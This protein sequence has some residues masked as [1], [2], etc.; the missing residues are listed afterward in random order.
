MV[1]L[2]SRRGKDVACS[3]PKGITRL[4]AANSCRLCG[5]RVSVTL[6]SDRARIFNHGFKSVEASLIYI[7]IMHEGGPVD[8]FH[9]VHSAM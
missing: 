2:V 3:L 6:D 1:S 5:L 8:A 9:S 7:L 4:R